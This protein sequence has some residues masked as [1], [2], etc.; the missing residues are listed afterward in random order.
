MRSIV[1][2]SFKA[3]FLAAFLTTLVMADTIVPEKIL[4]TPGLDRIFSNTP[5][6]SI[7]YI[8]GLADSKQPNKLAVLQTYRELAVELLKNN[9]RDI[10]PNKRELWEWRL[11]SALDILEANIRLVEAEKQ[12][13][14]IA[15]RIYIEMVNDEQRSIGYRAEALRRL[16][17]DPPKE[18]AKSLP[19]FLPDWKETRV[20]RRYWW[21]VHPE[22]TLRAVR[23]MKKVCGKEVL[24]LLD[25]WLREF[26]SLNLPLLS[27]STSLHD[28]LVDLYWDLRLKGLPVKEQIKIATDELFKWRGHGLV[29]REAFVKI[30]R[31]AV[32]TL[33][34]LLY[35]PDIEISGSAKWALE[36]I[37]DE[38]AIEHLA[39]ILDDPLYNP[40]IMNKVSTV[41]AIGRI[42]GAKA[43]K[44]LK[45]LLKRKN[46]HPFVISEALDGLGLIGD[47]SAEDLI[48]PFL[49]HQEKVVRYSAAEALK[50]C[51]TQKAV[52]ILLRRFE[53]ETEQGVL[54]AIFQALKALGAR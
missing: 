32:P 28:A 52:P 45:Q 8:R 46:E 17:D 30:G 48:L 26:Q 31:P 7:P 53:V 54:S 20:G 50:T 4:Y 41:G 10:D 40:R 51:G 5:T 23:M 3:V 38:R 22:T 13:S 43:A 1:V 44:V 6:G 11:R 19:I 49:E 35:I 18:I 47:K 24:P 12:P 21:K 29:P 36:K 14:E 27:M 39:S 2:W 42:G 37:R 16:E 25:D 33:I 15:R 34:E 9:K